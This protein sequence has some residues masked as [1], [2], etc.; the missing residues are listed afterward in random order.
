MLV[1]DRNR[2]AAMGIGQHDVTRAAEIADR[3]THTVVVIVV[4]PNPGCGDLFQQYG[5]HV[6]MIMEL[7]RHVELEAWR[8]RQHHAAAGV[9]AINFLAD[10]QRIL[11][12]EQAERVVVGDEQDAFA[13]GHV[14]LSR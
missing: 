8:R 11:D 13:V 2:L 10:A 6:P 14:S 4:K 9:H 1:D 12:A 3:V 5:L 7:L